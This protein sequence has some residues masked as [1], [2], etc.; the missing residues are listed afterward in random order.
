MDQ[1]QE[2]SATETSKGKVSRSSLENLFKKGK[3]IELSRQGN[4]KLG[5]AGSVAMAAERK[6][7]GGSSVVE[8]EEKKMLLQHSGEGNEDLMAQVSK[9]LRTKEKDSCSSWV[10][11]METARWKQ[12]CI[13]RSSRR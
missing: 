1:M 7:I 10:V 9:V 2:G 13:Y 11:E 8:I 5:G 3:M 12:H 6:T 4:E